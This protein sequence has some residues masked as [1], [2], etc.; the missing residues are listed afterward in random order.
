MNTKKEV[1]TTVDQPISDAEKFAAQND[2]FETCG[3]K[4]RR[5]WGKEAKDGKVVRYLTEEEAT[6]NYRA[7]DDYKKMQQ[8]MDSDPEFKKVM[9]HTLKWYNE[10]LIMNKVERHYDCIG[11]GSRAHRNTDLKLIDEFI[12]QCKNV[13]STI[14]ISGNGGHLS[15]R[16]VL[17]MTPHYE[18][19]TGKSKSK[20]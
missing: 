16:Y 4:L 17:C 15:C 2:V 5:Y 14:G 11:V 10:I 1:E 7:S 20:K 18:I 13:M 8:L 12:A 6:A 9:A 19:V 3:I